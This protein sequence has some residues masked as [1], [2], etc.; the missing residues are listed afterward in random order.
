MLSLMCFLYQILPYSVNNLFTQPQRQTNKVEH[1][2]LKNVTWNIIIVEHSIN[3]NG[4]WSKQNLG[5]IDRKQ[6]NI[7]PIMVNKKGLLKIIVT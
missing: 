5:Q 1:I 7:H 4:L 6:R 2:I 3:E